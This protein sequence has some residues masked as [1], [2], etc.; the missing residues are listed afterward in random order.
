VDP[1]IFRAYDIRG[2]VDVDFDPKESSSIG[3]A[4]GT[5]IQRRFGGKK[6]VVGHDNRFSSSEIN[7]Y[8]VHGLLSTGC[9]VTD[10]GLALTPLVHFAVVKHQYDAGCII[11]ASHNPKEFNGFRFDGPDCQPI[12]NNDLQE[13]RKLIEKNDFIKGEGKIAYRE[14]FGE[15][16]S[17]ISSRVHI[18]RKVKVV[19][20]CGNGAASEFAPR[21]YESLGV[22]VI[23]QHCALHGDF[24]YHT[25]DPEQQIN[26]VD[27][28]MRLSHDNADLA[29]GFDTDGDR[30]GVVDESGKMYSNDLLLIPL[31][32]DVLRRFPGTKILFD[33]KSSYVL[34]DEIEKAGGIPVMIRTGHP[35]FRQAMRQDP[36]ILIGG[37]VSS[38]TFIR[39][40]YYGYDDGLFAGL[41]VVELL[42]RTDEPF[43][44]F[45]RDIERTEATEEIRLPTPDDQ[46]FVVVNN[47]KKSLE[48]SFDVLTVDGVRVKF[49][50][51]AWALVRASNTTPNI[52]VRFEAEN[53]TKLQEIVEIIRSRLIQYPVVDIT[54]LGTLL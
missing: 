43:S 37:E 41:R 35:Y 51:R 9:D 42:S 40:N 46:K 20:D 1:K 39:D 13:I 4:F 49:S 27:S 8:F 54:P 50:D 29:I 24:P 23:T 52:T 11:T 3:K 12:F 48:N 18:Q 30:Y 47:I 28:I 36:S 17:D 34:S 32:K 38:H 25:A 33:V 22:E 45:F 26:M 44:E 53:P 31:S 16:A 21:L 6:V 15:Y 2:V 14:I 10:I 19:I 7:D 5:Y